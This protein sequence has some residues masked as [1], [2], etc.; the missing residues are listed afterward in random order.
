MGGP[1]GSPTPGLFW[2]ALGGMR[3]GEQEAVLKFVFARRRLPRAG[4]P[5]LVLARMAREAP[6]A[7]LPVGHTCAGQID[8][9]DY[10]SVEVMRGALLRAA[11]LSS[12]FDLDGGAQGTG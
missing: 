9:P 1:Q 6:D 12:V 11:S 4:G 3:A 10:S 8:L 7:A 2:R 5:A